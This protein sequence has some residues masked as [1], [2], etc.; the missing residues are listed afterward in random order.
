MIVC[1]PVVEL[2]ILGD[3]AQK[4]SPKAQKSDIKPVLCLRRLILRMKRMS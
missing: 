2:H 1:C 3:L 4:Q